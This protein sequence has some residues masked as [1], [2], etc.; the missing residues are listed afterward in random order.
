MK[1]RKGFI[2]NSSA[3]SFI[4][5]KEWNLEEVKTKLHRIL[6]GYNIMTDCELE[7]DNIFQEPYLCLDGDP[8]QEKEIEEMYPNRDVSFRKIHKILEKDVKNRVVIQGAHDNSIPYELFDIIENQLN[9]E[10][11]HLG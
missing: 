10:H 9:A 11:Y 4:C 7:F 3:A 1:I 6:E 8:F 2:S 5:G